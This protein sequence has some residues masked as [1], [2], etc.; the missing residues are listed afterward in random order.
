[1]RGV[2]ACVRRR[3]AAAVSV[4]GASAAGPAAP[5]AERA[6]ELTVKRAGK[7]I[8]VCAMNIP[9]AAGRPVSFHLPVPDY[10]L[11][12]DLARAGSDV[13]DGRT[14]GGGSQDVRGG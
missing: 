10:S 2:H 9:S 12:A 3:L 1:M 13:R 14:A 7:R 4:G 5:A 6:R 11:A 8:A